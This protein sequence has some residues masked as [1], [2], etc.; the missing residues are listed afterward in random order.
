ML[1]RNSNQHREVMIFKVYND[2]S[3][4]LRLTCIDGLANPLFLGR[5]ANAPSDVPTDLESMLFLTED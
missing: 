4:Q 3:K 1:P 2:Q 5:L